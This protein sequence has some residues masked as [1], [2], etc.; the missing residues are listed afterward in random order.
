MG[1]ATDGARRFGVFCPLVMPA[2]QL[3]RARPAPAM[4]SIAVAACLVLS[5]VSEG[6]AA[7]GGDQVVAA[8][9][10]AVDPALDGC[11]VAADFRRDVAR[12][13][14]YDPF[15]D[16]APQRV[17]VRVSVGGGARIAGRI[18]WRGAN[19]EGEG[20]RTFWSRSESCAELVRG[21]AF[22]M[23]IQIQLLAASGPGPERAGG[24][25]ADAGGGRTEGE[26]ANGERANGGAASALPPAAAASSE[27]RPQPVAVAA[28]PSAP[29]PASVPAAAPS[30][31]VLAGRQTRIGVAL[32]VG[33]MQ[34]LG[35][36]PVF[37][38]PRLAVS[39]DRPSG[40]GGRL[41][42]SGL[43]PGAQVTGLEGVARLDRFVATLELV[44]SFRA[45]R[46]VQPLLAA[47][48]GAQDIR[49]RGTSAM[50]VLAHAHAGQSFTA[51][52]TASGGAMV[53]LGARLWAIV[54]V[55]ALLFYPSVAVEVGSAEAAR[56]DG[57]TLFVHGGALARF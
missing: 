1:Q 55:Q 29:A 5:A 7:S 33:A 31:A 53:A 23:T 11:P 34:D 37:W 50:P 32:G 47:G 45:G 49:V 15:R 30:P 6:R 35:D 54:E 2:L 22:A 41:A 12:Q 9:D 39:L 56:L 48:A 38:L 27:A 46:I 13:L 3:R 43:G 8:L 21:M 17:V 51:L 19:D 42:V 57:V 14:G 10:Y 36:S 18:E 52:V 44:R 20:E 28:A 25:A 40:F 4:S 24:D 16:S 26:R